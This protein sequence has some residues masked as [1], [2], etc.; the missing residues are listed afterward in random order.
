MKC[1]NQFGVLYHM[2]VDEKYKY[3]IGVYH[4]FF[5]R[6]ARSTFTKFI[7]Y[8]LVLFGWVDIVLSSNI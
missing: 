8:R 5:N 1:L 4:V 7:Y 6:L 3:K 2:I